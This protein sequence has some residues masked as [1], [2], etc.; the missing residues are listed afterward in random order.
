MPFEQITSIMRHNFNSESRKL[1]L[2][3]DI[4]SLN[5]YTFMKKADLRDYSQS[6]SK[7]VD[8]INALA[9]QLPQGFGDDAHKTRYLRRAVMRLQWVQIPIAQLTTG[10]Y[11]FVQ[12]I[13]AL[14]ESSQLQEEMSRAGAHESLYGQYLNDSRD[15][16]RQ[17]INKSRSSRWNS[18]GHNNFSYS[19]RQRSRTPAG[20]NNGHHSC[21][22]RLNPNYRGPPPCYNCGSKNHKIA[23]CPG[24]LNKEDVKINLV[25]CAGCSDGNADAL[26]DGFVTMYTKYNNRT[27]LYQK[28]APMR[29]CVKSPMPNNSASHN[30]HF[31]EVMYSVEEQ[32]VFTQQIA[33]AFNS[34]TYSTHFS[35]ADCSRIQVAN[36]PRGIACVG[37][38]IDIGAPKSVVGMSQPNR[39][40]RNLEK[41]GIPR[42][43]S[44]NFFRFGDVTVP[45]Q[46][47]IE[48][49]LDTPPNF[50]PIH[51]L[52][53][54]VTV[55]IPALL[56]VD[57]LDG[58]TLCAENVT[59]RLVHRQIL[60]GPEELLK[61]ED[62]SNVPVI[63]YKGHLY[64]RMNFPRCSFYTSAQLNKMHRHF[65]HPSADKLFNLLKIAGTEAVD[66]STREELEK[67][68]ATCE[69][70]QR[71]KNAP[72]RFRTSMGHANIRFNARAYIEIMY[73]DG[74]PV[75][76]VVDEATRSSAARFLPKISTDAVWDAIVLCRSSAYTGL[77][78]N[79]MV[80]E[81]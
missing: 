39:I 61:Y 77:P 17:N 1:T 75:L 35:V 81:G 40:L 46:G 4:D 27:E 13:T 9:P 20:R 44:R 42:I 48:I 72:L 37:F 45:S 49:A 19:D 63:R 66:S 58:E 65:G 18:P 43:K 30:V 28:L 47:L 31:K 53:D 34:D 52:M 29:D 78:Q 74:R 68:V 24:T 55:D 32:E 6:L 59:N 2:K 11:T 12:F 38:C 69:P 73:L 41:K 60:S 51:V 21:S 15:I 5:L 80:D 25:E 8:R 10:R 57:V 70:C 16:S 79:M 3:T 76:H 7:L 23:D 71:I 14:N 56:E 33:Q 26:A 67:I 62:T 36:V 54:I 64:A 22:H 50:R